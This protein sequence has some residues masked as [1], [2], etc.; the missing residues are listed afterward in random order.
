MKVPILNE[1]RSYLYGDGLFETILV[2]EPGIG[3]VRWIERHL[4]RLR[5]SGSALGFPSEIIE[6]GCEKLT[7][8][9]ATEIPGIWRVT[10][11]RPGNFGKGTVDWG[12]TGGVT[13]RYRPF[14]EIE[15]PRLGTAD[16][17][18]LPADQLRIHKS[19][20]FLTY[21]EAKR[22]ARLQGFDDAILVSSDGLIGETSAA[23]IFVVIN[24]EISTPELKGIVSGVTRAGLLELAA[25]HQQ[26]IQEREIHITE[27]EGADEIILVSAGVGVI[28]AASLLGRRLCDSWGEQM[29]CWLSSDS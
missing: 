18:Y 5:A 1:D 2:P 14:I 4:A 13:A 11:S 20:S 12:G 24:G 9:A 6:E 25:Q 19:T 27:L 8:I 22:H 16:G 17:Y 3:N 7:L 29:R 26:P 10:V 21:V 28:S 15:R 23:N